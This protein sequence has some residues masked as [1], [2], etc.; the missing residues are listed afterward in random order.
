[1]I[2]SAISV[3]LVIGDVYGEVE[4]SELKKLNATNE[5]YEVKIQEAETKIT[6]LIDE[7]TTVNNVD[8]R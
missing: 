3:G 1:M 7:N 5:V 8:G 2:I 6:H 4:I